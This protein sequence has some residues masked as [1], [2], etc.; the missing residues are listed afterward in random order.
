[1]RPRERE[2]R[3]DSFLGRSEKLEIFFKALFESQNLL[4]RAKG[5]N[6]GRFWDVSQKI[7]Q[8]CDEVKAFTTFWDIL[9]WEDGELER[10]K[11][12]WDQEVGLFLVC[13]FPSSE[14]RGRGVFPVSLPIFL[15]DFLFHPVHDQTRPIGT[16]D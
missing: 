6:R 16:A 9:V 5:N 12:P 11:A 7:L 3:P 13:S 10:K 2:R 14:N 4:E 15:R 8:F 1:M